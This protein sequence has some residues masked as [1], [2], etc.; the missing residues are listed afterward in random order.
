MNYYFIWVAIS[1]IILFILYAYDKAQ[2]KGKGSR[3]PEVTLHWL[4][5]LGGWPGGWLGRA[6]F[7][8]KTR[9]S[10]FTLVLVLATAIHVFIWYWFLFR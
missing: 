1:S 10:V 4:A 8:H 3:I 9:K 6:T 7:R 2:A 5:L